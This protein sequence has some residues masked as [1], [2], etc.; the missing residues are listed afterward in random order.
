M[1][2]GLKRCFHLVFS[3]WKRFTFEKAFENICMGNIVFETK[4]FLNCWETFFL[5]GKQIL[6]PVAGKLGN[7]DKKRVSV[8]MFPFPCFRA[9]T[10]ALIGG[11]IFIYSCSARQISFEISCHY[12]WFQKKF[13]SRTRIYEYA[14]PPPINALVTALPCF[15]NSYWKHPNR[16]KL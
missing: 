8:T 11:W 4:M 13:E 9:V 16:S 12:S 1:E 3:C 10:K 14:P 6:F 5:L 7:I 15:L 2:T